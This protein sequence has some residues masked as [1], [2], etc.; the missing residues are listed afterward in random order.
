MVHSL[1]FDQE[2]S[3][4]LEYYKRNTID[5]FGYPKSSKQKQKE[6]AF[7]KP[8]NAYEKEELTLEEYI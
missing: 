2:M 5:P 6:E 3:L 7:I 4:Q 1:S 8:K